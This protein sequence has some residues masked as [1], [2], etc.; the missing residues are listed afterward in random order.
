MPWG[1]A[2]LQANPVIKTWF[3]GSAWLAGWGILLGMP[4]ACV[5]VLIPERLPIRWPGP[6]PLCEQQTDTPSSWLQPGLRSQ[7]QLL[8]FM[9]QVLFSGSCKTEDCLVREPWLEVNV[10][11]A[12]AVSVFPSLPQT[13]ILAHSAA[14][15]KTGCGLN[16]VLQTL[17]ACNSKI[18]D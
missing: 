9:C 7:G 13:K 11:D 1:I 2:R 8:K 16:I 5:A 10:T 4:I 17:M 12:K 14:L 18:L 15:W 6:L 3:E